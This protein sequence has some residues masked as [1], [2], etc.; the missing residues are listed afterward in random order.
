M[1]PSYI[2]LYEKGELL[3]RVKQ[4]YEM[5]E[6]CSVCPRGCGAKRLS[7]EKGI[8]K[9]GLYPEVSSYNP[10]F[11]EEPPIS[12]YNGSGTIFFTHCTLKCVYCQNYPIS[13]I[14]SGNKVTTGSLAGMMLFLQKKRCH[15]INLVTPTHFVP[16]ILAAL[17]IAVKKGLSV[18]LVYNTSGYESL[19]TL[20]LLDGIVDIYMPD[21]KYGDDTN[22][23]KYSSVNNYAGVSRMALKEMFRQVGNL[24]TDDNGAAVRGMLVRHL[25]MPDNI[26]GTRE[27]LK[28]LSEE[29]S[30]DI[31]L[32]LMSQYFPAYKAPGI[33]E[34]GRRIYREEYRDALK[35]KEEFELAN[36][37]VQDEPLQRSAGMK[38]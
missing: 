12:G 34:I 35:W 33:R 18:P 25:V 10:H 22:A 19:E 16:Q 24:R 15:N 20:K 37:W 29:I 28:F 17:Y 4:G 2:K 13:Q 38:I 8:C 32:A 1:I 30:K 23:L 11:G 31:Y 26:S 9:S 36:G 7:D 21:I 6:S 5:L 3:K 27:C 14:G